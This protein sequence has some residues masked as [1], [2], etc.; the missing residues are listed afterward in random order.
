MKKTLSYLTIVVL[1]IFL[2]GFAF[3][4]IVP[5]NTAHA[6]SEI[7]P[8]LSN[9]SPSEKEAV[10]PSH[11]AQPVVFVVIGLVCV[12]FGILAI[13]PLLLD[14]PS[15]LLQKAVQAEMKNPARR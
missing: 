15:Q 9:A 13:S 12:L 2:V 4:R 8:A 3:D 7:Q 11:L 6:A 1:A 10:P 14:E 5:A